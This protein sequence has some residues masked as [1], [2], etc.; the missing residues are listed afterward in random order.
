MFFRIALNEFKCMAVEIISGKSFSMIVSPMW[1]HGGLGPDLVARVWGIVDH[2]LGHPTLPVWIS[3][4]H[5]IAMSS[6]HKHHVSDLFFFRQK[7]Q[8]LV[9]RLY[10]NIYARI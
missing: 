1:P 4:P 9:V 10:L 7:L 8:G 2:Y 5:P 6:F 3:S